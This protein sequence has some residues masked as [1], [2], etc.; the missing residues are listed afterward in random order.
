MRRRFLKYNGL[1]IKPAQNLNDSKDDDFLIE[2][3]DN[4]KGYANRL[5]LLNDIPLTYLLTDVAD[6]PPESI[7]FG[8]IDKNW[9]DAYI[10]GAFSIGRICETDTSLDARF[11]S[12]F[13]GEHKL[14]FSNTPRMQMMHPNHKSILQNKKNND[15][16]I[17]IES[18]SV[19]LIRSELI[20]NQKELH[21]SA[22]DSNSY[23]REQEKPI[24]NAAPLDIL[25]IEKIS[26]DIMICLFSGILEVFIIDEPKTGLKFGGSKDTN[27]IDIDIRSVEETD[28]DFGKRYGSLAIQINNSEKESNPPTNNNPTIIETTGKVNVEELAKQIQIQINNYQNDERKKD[29]TKKLKDITITPSIFAFEMLSVPHK[30]VFSSQS[31]GK[32]NPRKV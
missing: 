15:T 30:A 19:V 16:E 12:K 4:L 7:R 23:D 31:L 11:Q 5:R 10:D 13:N 17:K 26:N 29:P 24:D 32:N 28:I 9:T 21:F 25:R 27:S 18:I 3:P 8:V 14:T 2:I 6:L 22:Y 1:G 20:K